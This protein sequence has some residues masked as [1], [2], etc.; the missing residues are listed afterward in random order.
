MF[1]RSVIH[2]KLWLQTRTSLFQTSFHPRAFK[3]SRS[4]VRL[5]FRSIST[6]AS[7]TGRGNNSDGGVVVGTWP[8]SER[9]SSADT[10]I[11]TKEESGQQQPQPESHSNQPASLQLEPLRVHQFD[12]YELVSALQ[13]AGFSQPQAVALMKCLRTVLI[14]GTEFAKSHYLSRGDLENVATRSFI[15]LME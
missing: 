14:Y 7:E 5:P 8:S 2:R 10:N 11:A 6:E 15:L 3:P 1:P 9:P 13:T 12:T 4:Q